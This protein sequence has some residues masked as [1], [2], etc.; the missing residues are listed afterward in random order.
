MILWQ[1]YDVIIHWKEIETCVNESFPIRDSFIDGILSLIIFL[2]LALSPI[3][4]PFM[5]AFG[6][7]NE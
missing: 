2:A 7:F 4:V 3:Y 5:I 1:S 6:F